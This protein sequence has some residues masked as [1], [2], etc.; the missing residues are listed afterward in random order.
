MK[1]YIATMLADSLTYEATETVLEEADASDLFSVLANQQDGM[2]SRFVKTKRRTEP[3]IRLTL[4]F[5]LA[6]KTSTGCQWTKGSRKN[7]FTF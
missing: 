1:S 4:F 5:D 2:D 3:S 6:V 7:N